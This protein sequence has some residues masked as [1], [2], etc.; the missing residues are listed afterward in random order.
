[1]T[2]EEYRTNLEKARVL[3]SL[4][5][6]MPEKEIEVLAAFMAGY[7]SGYESKQLT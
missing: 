1:M 5:M 7:K 3:I 2:A 6:P 4:I